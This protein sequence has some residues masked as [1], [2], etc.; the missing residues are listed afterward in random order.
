MYHWDTLVKVTRDG[1][2][3]T[4][5]DSLKT[6]GLMILLVLGIYLGLKLINK[7]IQ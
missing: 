2:E 1:F 7:F 4:D 3:V 5:A 6:V